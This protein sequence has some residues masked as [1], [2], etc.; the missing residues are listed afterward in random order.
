MYII[1]YIIV[2]SEW[3]FTI[4]SNIYFLNF[5]GSLYHLNNFEIILEKRN[6]ELAS[7]SNLNSSSLSEMV[8]STFFTK[9]YWLWLS[10]EFWLDISVLSCIPLFIS[11][12]NLCTFVNRLLLILI[13]KRCSRV[14]SNRNS[15]KNKMAYS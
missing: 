4:T 8:N 6:M 5:T 12:K 9:E 10:C 15:V 2:T 11:N 13:H 14:S 3:F 1:L 7:N